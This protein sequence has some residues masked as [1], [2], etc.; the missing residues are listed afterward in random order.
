MF[1]TIPQ[2]VHIMKIMFSLNIPLPTSSNQWDNVHPLNVQCSRLDVNLK[3]RVPSPTGK[4][5]THDV[6]MYVGAVPGATEA[7]TEDQQPRPKLSV[8][9]VTQHSWEEGL[10]PKFSG[11]GLCK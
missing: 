6:L 10:T 5:S 3:Y 2:D 9:R 11:T 4:P 7:A 8:H 1:S